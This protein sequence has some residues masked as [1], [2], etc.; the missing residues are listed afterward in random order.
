[1]AIEKPMLRHWKTSAIPERGVKCQC[2]KDARVVV[3]YLDVDEAGDQRG[4]LYVRLCLEC[5]E[6]LGN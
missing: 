5:K 4:V 2:G 6:N 3:A 1:M